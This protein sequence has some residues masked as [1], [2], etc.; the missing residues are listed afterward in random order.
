VYDDGGIYPITNAND[1]NVMK[2]RS[3]E[4]HH[5]VFSTITFPLSSTTALIDDPN[6]PSDIVVH[7]WATGNSAKSVKVVAPRFHRESFPEARAIPV[8]FGFGG[9]PFGY[10][11]AGKRGA[12]SG[13]APVASHAR[14][15]ATALMAPLVH[16][17]WQNQL[18][19]YREEQS[20]C[21]P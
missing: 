13:V 15:S 19:P 12:P 6:T 4:S 16:D 1:A 20:V 21:M 9:V 10:Q 8:S 11:T 5:P 3:T 7:R 18:F 14:L 17:G 2:R